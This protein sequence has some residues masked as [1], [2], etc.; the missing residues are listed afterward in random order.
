MR[1]HDIDWPRSVREKVEARH[2]LAPEEVESAV[3]D[4]RARIKKAGR[5]RYLLLGHA[6]SGAYISVVFAYNHGSARIITARRMNLRERR[7]YRR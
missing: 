4:R 7:I 3:F 1:I 2:G 5:D 6:D